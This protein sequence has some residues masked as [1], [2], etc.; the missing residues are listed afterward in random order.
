MQCWHPQ[1]GCQH[2]SALQMNA[3]LYRSKNCTEIFKKKTPIPWMGQV[4]ESIDVKMVIMASVACSFEARVLSAS[5]VLPTTCHR[6]NKGA[7]CVELR[8][9]NLRK[10]SWN[11]TDIGWILHAPRHGGKCICSPL[12]NTL[13][14]SSLPLRSSSKDTRNTATSKTWSL[15]GAFTKTNTVLDPCL[16]TFLQVTCFKVPMLPGVRNPLNHWGISSMDS[17]DLG[18]SCSPMSIT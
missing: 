3:L 1:C 9:E 2:M 4:A 11:Y 15:L 13:K 14:S 5:E 17:S 6:G 16:N 10:A 7:Q 18:W 12:C 8:S